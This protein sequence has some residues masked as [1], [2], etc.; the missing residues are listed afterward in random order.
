M[1]MG[2]DV[3]GGFVGRMVRE[4][5]WSAARW[6][7]ASDGPVDRYLARRKRAL[8]AGLRGHVIEIGPGEGAS[9]RHLSAGVRW[10]GVEPDPVSRESALR[11]ARRVG[12]AA[13][14]LDGR[15]EALP[16]G[17]GSVDAVISTLVL[18]SVDDL[19]EALREVRRVLRPGGR[20]VFI[21]HVGATPG[22]RLRSL[23]ERLAP[24]WLGVTGECRLARDTEAAISG[25]GFA[26]V[27]VE[28]FSMGPGMNPVS[29]GIAG[30]AV[31]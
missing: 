2:D 19:G 23:Q 27:Q 29:P 16:V 14:V 1:V 13:M 30:V 15:A 20:F 21:E 18:C 3:G 12:I 7:L 28:R 17:D 31:A 11:E 25:A 26:T 5:I 6:V 24:W 4:A 22:S 8:F 9:L 10:I